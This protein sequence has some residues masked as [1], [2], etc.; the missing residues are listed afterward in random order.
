MKYALKILRDLGRG[1]EIVVAADEFATLQLELDLERSLPS[2]CKISHKQMSP[3]HQMFGILQDLARSRKIFQDVAKCFKS[4]NFLQ[5]LARFCLPAKVPQ[6]NQNYWVIDEDPT[7]YESSAD[8]YNA[9][10]AATDPW[11]RVFVTS[12]RGT[13]EKY[14]INMQG[15]EVLSESVRVGGRERRLRLLAQELPKKNR[16]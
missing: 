2:S 9:W 1:P 16:K 11:T 15:L 6:N 14:S 3:K 8:T 10:K 12:W 5:D 13:A 4:C 7:V